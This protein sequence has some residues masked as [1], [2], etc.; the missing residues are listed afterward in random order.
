VGQDEQPRSGS[1]IGY[2]IVLA[3]LPIGLVGVITVTLFYF[4]W[5][6]LESAVALLAFPVAAIVVNQQ[7]IQSS[8]LGRYPVAIREFARGR[9]KLLRG[10]W[11][12]VTDP[13]EAVDLSIEVGSQPCRRPGG[14]GRAGGD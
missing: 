9:F 3:R 6:V 8:W 10:I 13:M 2:L 5:L 12:W 7:W 4:L 11:A 1:F 14:R